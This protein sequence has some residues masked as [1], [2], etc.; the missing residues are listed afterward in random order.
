[1]LSTI[2][3]DGKRF[4]YRNTLRQVD[5]LPFEL[6][7]SH[8]REPY[9][10]C[11]CC[12]PNIVRTIAKVGAYAY[13]LTDKGVWVNLYGA[14]V[15]DTR[16]PDGSPIKLVQET[17]Y[18]WDSRILITLSQVPDTELSVY[19]RIPAWSRR[20]E[21]RVNGQG[22]SSRVQSGQYYEIKRTWAEGDQIELI[23]P[24]TVQ[25]LEAHPLVEETR[26]QVAVR[27]GPIVYC[28]ESTDLPKGVDISE[29]ALSRKSKW[30]SRY[31]SKLLGGITILESEAL[32]LTNNNWEATLYRE[33]SSEPLK[34]VTI[35]LIPY[36]AWGNRG[37]S[38]MTVWMPLR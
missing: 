1:V 12:P 18:P 34:T 22:Q 28:L 4:F 2:S 15:L 10:S 24:M 38:E 25:L 36:Y 27:R 21:V 8:R 20:A 26:N 3:L 33:I 30:N 9:I 35:H 16:L 19:L 11:F 6:R 5:D 23:L 13:S 14:N 17:E 29:V 32:R 31:D 37:D 7:W